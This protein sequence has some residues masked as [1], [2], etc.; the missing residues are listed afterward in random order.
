[1]EQNLGSAGVQTTPEEN[2]EALREIY[3]DM[4]HAGDNSQTC[5]LIGSVLDLTELAKSAGIEFEYEYSDFPKIKKLILIANHEFGKGSLKAKDL[6][7]TVEM[8][9]RF[10]EFLVY[11][12]EHADEHILDGLR[13]R[14]KQAITTGNLN[15][16]KF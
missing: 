12:Q 4:I 5:K 10:V 9:A 8:I 2:Y 11:S 13:E 16:L 7:I 15:V 1:M 3:E 6:E 14:L